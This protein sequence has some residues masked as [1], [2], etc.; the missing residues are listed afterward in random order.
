MHKRADIFAKQP[1]NV[2]RN[3]M[4]QQASFILFFCF[5]SKKG[6][7]VLRLF[8]SAFTFIWIRSAFANKRCSV[9]HVILSV[10]VFW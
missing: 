8:Y 10:E 9:A 3:K 4:L 6:S 1:H 7:Y 5:E 2:Y